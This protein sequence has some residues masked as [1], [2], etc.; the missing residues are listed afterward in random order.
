[1]PV[2][3]NTQRFKRKAELFDQGDDTYDSQST[4]PSPVPPI[5]V[6]TPLPDSTTTTTT[7]ASSVDPAE[8]DNYIR[9]SKE[10]ETISVNPPNPYV[11]HQAQSLQAR[12][13]N[14]NSNKRQK[15]METDPL[16]DKVY[17]IREV[18]ARD[19]KWE[20]ATVYAMGLGLGAGLVAG[21]LVHKWFFTS[22]ATTYKFAE[23]AA[24]VAEEA[25][26]A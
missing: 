17:S 18:A 15:T 26:A 3:I 12:M 22:A 7:T 25:V 20:Q 24:E 16:E 11:A 1:M 19:A 8:R 23:A 14:N 10:Q 6:Q 13:A 21:F 4:Q 2:P 5:S 9:Q